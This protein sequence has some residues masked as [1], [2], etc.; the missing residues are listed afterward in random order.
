MKSAPFVN[1]IKEEFVRLMKEDDNDYNED[2]SDT[3]LKNKF[4]DIMKKC[5]TF[6]NL[7]P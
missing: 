6:D 4:S 1:S 3:T 7:K 2:R 5:Q